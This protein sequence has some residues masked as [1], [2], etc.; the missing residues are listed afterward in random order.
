MHA[1]VFVCVKNYFL[2]LVKSEDF[3]EEKLEVDGSFQTASPLPMGAEAETFISAPQKVPTDT[4]TGTSG[5]LQTTGTAD[6]Q[7]PSVTHTSSYKISSHMK[8]RRATNSKSESRRQ[9]RTRFTRRTRAERKPRDPIE[10]P[11]DFPV[12]NLHCGFED[13]AVDWCKVGDLIKVNICL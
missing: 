1:C 9:E 2:F 7:K 10:T 12:D 8:L 11:N 3:Y 4:D 13:V 5:S 6:K